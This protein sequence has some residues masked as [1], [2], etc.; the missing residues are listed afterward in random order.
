MA[1][2]KAAVLAGTPVTVGIL[3]S[4]DKVAQADADFHAAVDA[5]VAKIRKGEAELAASLKADEEK[6]LADEAAAKLPTP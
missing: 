2:V 6:R 5:E 4:P 3:P 1:K